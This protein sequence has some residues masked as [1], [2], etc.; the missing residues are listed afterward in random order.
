MTPA[1]GGQSVPTQI[2]IIGTNFATDVDVKIGSVACSPLYRLSSTK[3]S[4]MV[5]PT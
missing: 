1:N 3:V 4:C 2:D 5:Q